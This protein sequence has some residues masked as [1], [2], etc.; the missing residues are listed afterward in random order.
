MSASLEN[1]PSWALETGWIVL[2]IA[3][4]AAF[5]GVMP[6]APMGDGP[7]LDANTVAVAIVEE[8]PRAAEPEPPAEEP[9][10][11]PEEAPEPVEPPP[12]P[13]TFQAPKEPP[14][15]PEE[16]P[17]AAPE[18]PVAFDNLVLTNEGDEPS[19]WAVDPGSG[20]SREGPIGSPDAVV[21]GRSREGIAGGVLG[22]TGTGV[23]VDVGDLSKQ[24]IPPALRQKLER[25]Y[26]KKARQEGVEGEAVIRLQIGPDGMPSKIRIVSESPP[27]YE[28]GN[29]CL[30]TLEGERWEPPFGKDGK[31]V[32]TR[33]TYRCGFE[34]RY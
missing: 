10:Q 14:K 16:P 22:G 7:D 29:A 32:T 20:E 1:L 25:L 18:T 9:P 24:P 17:A 23:V 11:T 15:A 26:P 31:P 6:K 34:I 30:K 27:G 3:V 28:L 13:K 4:H 21:T 12:A 5:L 8:E 2:A 19:S 33:V